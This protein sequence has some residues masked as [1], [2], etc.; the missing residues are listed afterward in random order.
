MLAQNALLSVALVITLFALSAALLIKEP[1][2]ERKAKPFYLS[3]YL[4]S[5]LTIYMVAGIPEYQTET[6]L[7]AL[8]I[9]LGLFTSS[10][11]IGLAIRYR[12]PAFERAAYVL[13]IIYLAT[14]LFIERQLELNITISFLFV[15]ISSVLNMLVVILRRP[16]PN[17]ADYGLIATLFIWVLLMLFELEVSEVTNTKNYFYSDIMLF[18]LIFL[19]AYIFGFTIFLLASYLMDSNALLEKLATKDELTDM[20]NRRALFDQI[21]SQASY[22]KRKNSCASVVI[23]DID[24]FKKIN[25]SYGHEAGDVAIKQFAATIHSSVRGYDIAA[26]YGGEEFLIFLPGADTE[27]ASAVAERIR[28]E[29]E[30]QPLDYQG[31]SIPFT[32][33]FGVSEYD[34]TD[35][36]DV[37]IARADKALYQSKSLGRNQITIYD[38]AN[39]L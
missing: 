21:S 14:M 15:L 26:R 23:A 8:D 36:S 39:D 10:H 17:K 7:K 3:F 6:E 18:Q 4:I 5:M 11:S 32:A 20:L 13:G 22:L 1:A 37:S 25:D 9:C 24:H 28:K 2:G 38:S 35:S 29:T 19:P 27:T 30:Q 34:L 12:R 16:K 31:K 33:S